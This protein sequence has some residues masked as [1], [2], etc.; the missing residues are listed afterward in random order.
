MHDLLLRPTVATLVL[1]RTLAATRHDDRG[2]GVIS[3]A[4][5]VLIMAL[6][7]A[8]LWVAFNGIFE[9]ATNKATNEIG[10]IGN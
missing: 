6:I 4:I 10:Q 7:G 2:E 3:A 1:V 9:D 5:V 8:G